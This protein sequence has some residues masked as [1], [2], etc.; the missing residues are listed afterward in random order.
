MG[1]SASSFS[2]PRF[3]LALFAASLLACLPASAQSNIANL[4]LTTSP[5]ANNQTDTVTLTVNQTVTFNVSMSGSVGVPTGYVSYQPIQDSSYNYNNPPC[6][7]TFL[8]SGKASCSYNGFTAG[9]HGAQIFYGGDGNYQEALYAYTIY[10]VNKGSPALCVV[11]PATSL[12]DTSHS[13]YIGTYSSG[14]AVSLTV[15]FSGAVSPIVPSG[16]ITF[17]S[18]NSPISGCTAVAISNGSATCQTSTLATGTDY[19]T[20]TY[21]GDSNFTT[22]SAT[23]FAFVEVGITPTIT[24]TIPTHHTLDAPF[25]VSANSNSPGT[26]FYSINSGPASISG[27]TVTLDGTAGAV[28][29]FASQ[30]PSGNYVGGTQTANFNV[31]AGSVWLGDQGGG[32]SVFGSDGIPLLSP[33][34]AGTGTISAPQSVAFDSAYNLWIASTNG[35]SAVSSQGTPLQSSAFTGGGIT[36]P[37][38]LAVDGNSYIWI[39]N[40][41]GTVSTLNN[42][43]TAL[44]PSNGYHWATAGTPGALAIDLSGNIWITTPGSNHITEIIGAAAPTAPLSTAITNGTVGTEP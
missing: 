22:A 7:Q 43:G 6:P 5:A 21:A 11:I 3:L 42:T 23:Q 31:V 33:T 35:V 34:G 25:N 37:V 16:T 8:S 41:N 10:Q 27:N 24:F 14:S 19:I 44:S 1:L 9:S 4:V 32:I 30:V 38:S 29:V 18:N 36:T 15:S 20:A 39:A 28:Q 26:I 13:G 2:F 12:C 40:S 17:F